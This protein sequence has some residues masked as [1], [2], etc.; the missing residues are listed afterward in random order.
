MEQ[1]RKILGTPDVVLDKPSKQFPQYDAFLSNHIN[2]VWIYGVR[3]GSCLPVLGHVGFGEYKNRMATLAGASPPPLDFPELREST[4]LK[5]LWL[6]GMLPAGDADSFNPYDLMAIGKIF[7]KLGKVQTYRI[8]EECKRLSTLGVPIERLHILMLYLHEPIDELEFGVNWKLYGG[9]QGPVYIASC[10]PALSD[11]FD[12][13]NF[14]MIYLSGLPLLVS[15]DWILGENDGLRMDVF[16]KNFRWRDTRDIPEQIFD[17][18]SNLEILAR[19][20]RP[21][22][23]G[24]EPDVNNELERILEK[25]LAKKL[26]P[27]VKALAEEIEQELKLNQST[28]DK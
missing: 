28:G 6:I 10:S 22:L 14:P 8:V 24:A 20:S 5:L 11:R 7:S 4:T 18:K 25:Q 26:S 23:P 9:L 21:L 12:I 27:D 15:E 2:P 17:T 13:R 19:I 3:K 16:D 1:V